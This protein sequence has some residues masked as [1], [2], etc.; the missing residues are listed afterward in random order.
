M[1]T[2]E[3]DILKQQS[4]RLR[5]KQK[6]ALIKYLSEGLSL[7]KNQGAPKFLEFGK[8]RNTGQK[9]STREDFKIAEWHPTEADLNGD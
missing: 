4:G 5:P 6:L 3:L 9:A 2:I 1:A 8:Y 7:E